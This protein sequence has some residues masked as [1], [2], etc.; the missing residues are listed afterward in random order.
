VLYTAGSM[1][2][3]R[4]LTGRRIAQRIGDTGVFV[5]VAGFGSDSTETVAFDSSESFFPHARGQTIV[6]GATPRDDKNRGSTELLTLMEGSFA[7]GAELALRI[8]VGVKGWG[9]D[10]LRTVDIEYVADS[11]VP[12]RR[13]EW[14]G[15]CSGGRWVLEGRF[16]E[17]RR[18]RYL[19]LLARQHSA[20]A[21]ALYELVV[22][23][24]EQ[25]ESKARHAR[26]SY[27]RILMLTPVTTIDVLRGQLQLPRSTMYKAITELK[28][29]GR[30]G[31]IRDSRP[32]RSNIRFDVRAAH[33]RWRGDMAAI[34]RHCD[35][36]DE[37]GDAGGAAEIDEGAKAPA[38][39]IRSRRE[40]DEEMWRMDERRA[41]AEEQP[42]APAPARER[43]APW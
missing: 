12:E 29:A 11:T 28:A 18:T 43:R 8:R 39:H 4:A 10:P 41:R 3:I 1:Q 5:D 35:L 13:E 7:D 9:T 37:F 22:A 33:L 40:S 16:R 26:Q 24:A 15:I 6:R 38:H 27:D 25:V 30:V 31:V 32:G 20:P 21:K 17:V 34:E 36:L 14:P 23:T 19:D 2:T 42:R